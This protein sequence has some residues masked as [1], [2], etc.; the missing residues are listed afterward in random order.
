[1][2]PELSSPERPNANPVFE[3]KIAEFGHSLTEVQ[4]DQ[5]LINQAGQELISEFGIQP[6]LF[7]DNAHALMFTS[8]AQR[9]GRLEQGKETMDT[10]AYTRDKE[11]IADAVVLLA[12][13]S[14]NLFDQTKDLIDKDHGIPEERKQAVYEKY[15]DK[16]LTKELEDAISVGLFD[17]VKERMGITDEN[18][19]E[20][21]VRVLSLGDEY[22]SLGVMPGIL[23]I[24][25][26]D[27]YNSPTF[28]EYMEDSDAFKQYEN[29]MVKRA[30]AFREELGAEARVPIAWVTTID[31]KRTL[32]MPL[33]F[34]EKVLYKDEK[35][36]GYYTEDDRNRD[37]AI[38][39]HEY[40][41]TQ[42][43]INLDN[44]VLFGIGLEER[45]AEYFSGD[46][47]G[48]QEIKGFFQDFRVVT[49]IDIAEI[50][51]SMPKG[52]TALDVYTAL[53]ERIGLQATLELVMTVP[54]PYIDDSRP[55]QQNVE[56]YFGGPDSLTKKLYEKAV[57][58]GKKDQV[59][60]GIDR[61]ARFIGAKEEFRDFWLSYRKNNSGL[62]FMTDKYAARM[63]ELV[64][65]KARA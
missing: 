17:D 48:Y 64:A 58:E 15:T 26:A 34:A 51:D 52:G 61:I 65:E 6:E 62:E 39:K 5:E 22:S 19:D 25:G 4:N 44:N 10:G 59:E 23:D 18:E 3:N 57:E 31:G 32:C 54:Q 60:A 46:K 36:A 56:K 35:R 1:M 7:D 13:E 53:A 27:D 14:S 47:Q 24:E 38:M 33:P 16:T 21:D 8:I 43:G 37:L 28:E 12:G 30:Q 40:V 9:Y 29:D 55:L 2:T 42:G 41:H 20:Y 49:G 50:F 11:F 45:R 63:E